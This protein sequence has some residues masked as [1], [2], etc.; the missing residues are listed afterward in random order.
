MKTLSILIAVFLPLCLNSTAQAQVSAY[1][2]AAKVDG[3]EISNASLEASFEEYQ[4]DNNVNI[5]AVRYPG[6]VVEMRG[7]VLEELVNQ[8]LVWQTV[9]EKQL[10]ASP[11]EV[12]KALEEVREQFDTED[13]LIRRITIDGFTPE[14]YRVHVQKQVSTAKY[15]QNVSSRA[16]VSRE[17][18]HEFYVNNPDKLQVPETVRSRHILLTVHPNADENTRKG[19]RDKMDGII[20]Q[21]ANG[22]DFATL[23]NTYSD[24]ESSAD[25]GDLGY[26]QHGQMVKPFDDAAF[27]LNVGEISGIVETVYGLHV[28]KLED[29]QPRQTVTEEMAFEQIFDY[30]MQLKRRQALIDEISRLRRNAE[31]EILVAQ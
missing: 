19:V 18:V 14:S 12:D 22:A 5:S 26:F 11:E 27:A 9:K 13:G 16:T 20:E 30:L 29:R 7:E 31:I 15:M 8:E 21:L 17:E 3:V 10:I 6:R 25:G 1:G 24:D 28:I 4:R 2:A 23:A